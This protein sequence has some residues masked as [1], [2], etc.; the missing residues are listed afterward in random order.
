VSKNIFFNFYVLFS[1]AVYFEPPANLRD[2]LIQASGEKNYN[3]KVVDELESH[4]THLKNQRG[5]ALVAWLQLL[6]EN[7]G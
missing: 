6:Q 4:L 1:R 7:I 3:P 2:L 5:Q